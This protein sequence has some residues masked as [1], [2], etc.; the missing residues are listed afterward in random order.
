MKKHD[1]AAALQGTPVSEI[2][3]LTEALYLQV[4]ANVAAG[5]G[6][7][8]DVRALNAARKEIRECKQLGIGG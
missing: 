6:T 3:K 1:L 5:N 4:K 7:Q 8:E 2:L